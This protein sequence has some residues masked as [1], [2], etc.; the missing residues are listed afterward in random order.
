MTV[1]RVLQYLDQFDDDPAIRAIMAHAQTMAD[2]RS[3]RAAS[4]RALELE[5]QINL[6][7]MEINST[8]WDRVDQTKFTVEWISETLSIVR[9]LKGFGFYWSN[10]PKTAPVSDPGYYGPFTTQSEAIAA[11]MTRNRQT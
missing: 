10:N 8:Y 4:N 9:G 2:L 5:D 6:M 3:C 11:G 7:G 1:E